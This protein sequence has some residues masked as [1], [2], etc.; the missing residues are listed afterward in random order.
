M[1]QN[2]LR[3]IFVF[4]TCFQNTEKE[5]EGKHSSQSSLRSLVQHLN[6][7]L[8]FRHINA[9]LFIKLCLLYGGLNGDT[10]CFG[11]VMCKNMMTG[12]YHTHMSHEIVGV[13][14]D[15]RLTFFLYS[16][17]STLVLDTFF[18]EIGSTLHT[19][20]FNVKNNL[21][22]SCQAAQPLKQTQQ[23]V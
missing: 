12:L 8:R 17:I 4:P 13:I 15:G 5:E 3:T 18:N 10:M 23:C 9:N 1:C 11:K 2:F 7:R 6:F 21:V 14:L 19:P 20:G 16:T 22:S